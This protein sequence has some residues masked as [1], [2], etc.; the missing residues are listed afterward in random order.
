MVSMLQNTKI[1]QLHR[2]AEDCIPQRPN[3]VKYQL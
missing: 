3:D 2:H 1:I